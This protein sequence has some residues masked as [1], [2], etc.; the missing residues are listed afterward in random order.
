M[1]DR[2]GLSGLTAASPVDVADLTARS[3]FVNFSVSASHS[4]GSD[5]GPSQ[6]LAAALF[7]ASLEGI[8]YRISHDPKLGLEA[9]AVF[10]EPGEQP[11]RFNL[12]KTGLSTQIAGSE[13]SAPRWDFAVHMRPVRHVRNRCV[14]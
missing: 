11:E 14:R 6:E 3:V 9:I 4:T 10:G 2:D 13:A 8:R 1:R 12:P 7:V 5:Y